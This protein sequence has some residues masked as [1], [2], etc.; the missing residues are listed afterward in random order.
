M[1]PKK[2]STYQT[3]LYLEDKNPPHSLMS[4][5]YQFLNPSL[6]KAEEKEGNY[7]RI[8]TA[9]ICVES[10]LTLLCVCH[11]EKIYK[12]FIACFILPGHL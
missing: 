8:H 10:R 7:F 12:F 4:V 3:S 2:I 9:N 11:F 1:V 5:L 6:R